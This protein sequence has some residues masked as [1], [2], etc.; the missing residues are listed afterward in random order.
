M[1]NLKKHLKLHLEI[2]PYKCDECEM[3]YSR[4]DHLQRHLITHSSDPKPFPCELCIQRFS[5]KSHLNR[6]VKNIHGEGEKNI[7][8]CDQ[9]DM[10]F[11]KKHKMTKHMNQDHSDTSNNK[12]KCYY[13]FCH[14]IYHSKGKL[15]THIE[16]H[17]EIINNVNE[18]N[19]N[20]KDNSI[21][22]FLQ[23]PFEDCYKT[24]TTPFNL[25]VHIKTYHYKVEEF[26]CHVE[27]C[28]QSFK[29]KCSLD[30]HINKMHSTDKTNLANNE[31]S[32]LN[33]SNNILL[34]AE[35]N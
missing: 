25:K 31:E 30:R 10:S 23:C 9:C 21:K 24:Y 14:R 5:N 26:K 32:E 3:S 16:K 20:D 27:G 11:N 1:K 29:H 34:L 22:K 12:Y 35:T 15:D 13:P 28:G 18:V 19:N 7:Y 4:S 6:H 33:S 8:K 2:K 17:H